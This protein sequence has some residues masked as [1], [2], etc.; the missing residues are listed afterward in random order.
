VSSEHARPEPDHVAALHRLLAEAFTSILVDN[1]ALESNLNPIIEE[2]RAGVYQP[3]DE[4]QGVPDSFFDELE[5]VNKKSLKPS[6]TCSICGNAF[7][8]GEWF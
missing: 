6:D 5:R 3:P 4:L 2:L 7:L 1:E 8:D